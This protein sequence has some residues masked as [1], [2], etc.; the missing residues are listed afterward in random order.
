L[1]SLANQHTAIPD[2]FSL[3]SFDRE[4]PTSDDQE[5]Y[6][7]TKPHQAIVISQTAAMGIW[8]TITDIFEAAA[9]WSVVE[10]EAPAAEPQV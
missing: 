4:L 10:A 1:P 2:Q 9:P 7:I 8:D 6:L 5:R 3:T